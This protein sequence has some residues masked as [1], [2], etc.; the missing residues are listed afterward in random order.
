MKIVII[1]QDE[2]FYLSKVLTQFINLLPKHHKVIGC[3]VS[4]VSPFGKHKS[5][6]RKAIQTL[7]VFGLKFFVHY[8]LRF[9]Y[10]KFNISNSVIS[11]LERN[12]I[13]RI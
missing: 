4:S 8:T 7:T 12:N 10:S 6:F 13:K 11:I 2:P 1:T 3:V 5:F 9:I